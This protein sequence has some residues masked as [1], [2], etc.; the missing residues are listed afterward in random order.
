LVQSREQTSAHRK[1]F[2]NA[3]I[4]VDG[5]CFMS[6]SLFNPEPTAT[7]DRPLVESHRIV[8]RSNNRVLMGVK[9][10]VAAGSG[11]N[12]STGQETCAL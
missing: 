11:L 1:R 6:Q 8:A 4:F 3:P 9:S 10:A 7:A 5:V 12:E 2:L